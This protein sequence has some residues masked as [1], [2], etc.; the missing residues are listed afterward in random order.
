[1]FKNMKVGTKIIGGFI[2]TLALT[3][4]I[5]GVSVFNI[6][7]LGEKINRLATLEIP[8]TSAV[9]ET[10]RTMWKTHV[11]SYEFDI[12][13]DEKT[14]NEWFAEREKVVEA[15]E[16][17]IPISTALGNQDVIQAA[18]E[19]KN[20]IAA[21][22]KIGEEYVSLAMTNTQFRHQMEQDM[23][24]IRQQ[25]R[26]Y[27]HGQNQKIQSSISSDN[28]VDVTERVTKLK[29]ANQALYN[30][31]LAEELM[32]EYVEDQ[33]AETL[34]AILEKVAAF[35]KLSEKAF[36]LSSTADD[37][38]RKELVAVHGKKYRTLAE[39]W[40]ADRKK[41][42]DLLDRSDA[43][44]MA[45]ID[46][47]SRTARK[48]DQ[49]A[50]DFGISADHHAE[51]VNRFL[52]GLLLGAVILGAI[53]AFFITR[54]ITR[55]LNQVI[56]G[57]NEGSDQLASASG[58]V[59]SSSQSM[60]DGASQQAASIEETSSSMEEV[61][62]MTRRNA[63][64]AGNAD[65]LMKETNLVVTSASESMQKLTQSMDDISKASAETSNII[66]TIDEIAFQTNLLALNAAVEAARAGEAGAGFAVVADE[67]RNLAMRAASAAKD[68]AQLI[69]GT[70]KEVTNGSQLA[71]ATNDNFAQVAQS[72]S[73]VGTLVSEISQA[74]IEQSTGIDEVNTAISEM[75]KVVQQNASGAEESASAAEEMNAQAQQ[76]K[77][78]VADLLMMVT[79]TKKQE[80]GPAAGHGTMKM[81]PNQMIP[82][83]ND[84][85][86]KDI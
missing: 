25:L 19:V 55:P 49:A 17:I 22:R 16:K 81:R 67:V 40:S 85:Q 61:A 2:I 72:V 60:A 6:G 30:T 74:S 13:I 26:D 11:L 58:Q 57:L 8:E 53:L 41:Q 83:H 29:L 15:A 36:S 70:V 54:V 77:E 12:H 37:M 34:N 52:I 33:K 20:Q 73:K 21:Y 66:K 44:A 47:A 27:I 18:D 75:D 51:T 45:I 3:V 46:L 63:E 59:S 38:R 35:S 1:M 9:V 79:G 39:Q 42:G 62:A 82:F 71:S 43:L 23:D 28:W 50:Y 31:L 78:Y 4:I 7:G 24:V 76:L 64:N 80:T 84:E 65:G 32:H 5:G 68:T 56:T 10:E 14:K 48:A 86:F 69:D